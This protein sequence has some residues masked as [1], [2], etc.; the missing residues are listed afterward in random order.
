MQLIG[1][2]LVP[3]EPLFWRE[4][5]DQIKA[6][7]QNLFKFNKAMIKRAQ[8]KGAKFSVTCEN[9]SECIIA[10]AAGANLLV[11]SKREFTPKAAN[12]AQFYLFDAKVACIIGDESELSEIAGDQAD[13]AIFKNAVIGKDK[14]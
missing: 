8:E 13:V 11:I 6:D 7:E 2:E 3:Y 4:N 9:V 12:L 5:A 14:R 1:H 10:N